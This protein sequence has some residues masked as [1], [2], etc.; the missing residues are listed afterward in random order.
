MRRVTAIAAG[1]E[2][3]RFNCGF[4]HVLAFAI[5]LSC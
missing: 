3:N 4:R 2:L 1:A 5:E